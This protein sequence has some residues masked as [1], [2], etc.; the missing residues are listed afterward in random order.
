MVEGGGK[1]ALGGVLGGVVHLGYGVLHGMICFRMVRETRCLS[2]RG[3]NRKKIYSKASRG[4]KLFDRLL[5]TCCCSYHMGCPQVWRERKGKTK[6]NPSIENL[7][8]ALLNSFF[9]L[10][11]H[12][13]SLLKHPSPSTKLSITSYH[14]QE[15][16]PHRRQPLRHA[17]KKALPIRRHALVRPDPLLE[18]ARV[19]VVDR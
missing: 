1:W 10:T 9:I 11:G 15:P 4:I 7:L 16:D 14:I 6:Q 12:E 17:R 18:I 3:M 13:H 2:S 8:N 19:P 5:C